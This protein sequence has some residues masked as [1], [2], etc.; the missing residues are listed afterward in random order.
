MGN[1]ERGPRIW[2]QPEAY[3]RKVKSGRWTSTRLAD[4]LDIDKT[5]LSHYAN[6]RRPMPFNQAVRLADFLRCDVEDIVEADRYICTA[7]GCDER[8]HGLAA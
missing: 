3:R 2:I 4:R 8:T 7:C 1:G 5:L 6:A